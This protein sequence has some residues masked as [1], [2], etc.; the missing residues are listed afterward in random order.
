MPILVDDFRTIYPINHKLLQIPNLTKIPQK[1]PIK[2]H[3]R[4]IQQ[5]KV[6][7]GTK[8][9]QQTRHDTKQ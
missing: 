4:D 1:T 7:P 6:S 2:V 9:V 3:S 8:N 5:W